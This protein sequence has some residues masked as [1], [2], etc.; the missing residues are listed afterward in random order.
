MYRRFLLSLVAGAVLILSLCGCT[1]V[2]MT[3]R[4]QLNLIPASEMMSM[5]YQQYAEVVKG[6]KLSGDSAQVRRIRAVGTRIQRAVEG[7]FA[8][9]GQSDQLRD[10]KW[11]FNLIES[12]EMNAWCMPGGKV[13]FYTGILPVCRDDTGIAVVMGHEVAHAVAEHG[14]E[15]MSQALLTQLGGVALSTAISSEPERTQALWMGAFGLGAQY[16]V[17]L[18]FSRTQESESD[19]L[20]LVFMA[21][22]GYHPEAALAFWQRMASQGTGQ[23]PPEFLSTHPSDE[24]RMRKIQELLPEA[25]K[26]YRPAGS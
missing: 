15:R 21:R 5:S 6:S 26:Q 19:H 11:E 25:Q 22:A 13:A 23:A 2:A 3:G 1:K 4:S 16:G 24:T 10:Y 7:Y 18:P 9:I 8:E 12:D 20:G 17:L 14:A